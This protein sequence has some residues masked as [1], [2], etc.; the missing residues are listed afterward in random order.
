MS[1][2]HMGA[3]G[4]CKS[5]IRT[6]QIMRFGFATDHRRERLQIKCIGTAQQFRR[7]VPGVTAVPAGNRDIDWQGRTGRGEGSPRDWDRDFK[8]PGRP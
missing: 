6:P 5:G 7:G 8:I 3:D 2:A 4:S 1:I